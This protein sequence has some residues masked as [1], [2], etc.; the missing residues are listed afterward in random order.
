[1]QDYDRGPKLSE[2]QLMRE[3]A[4]AETELNSTRGRL[5]GEIA[6]LLKQQVHAGTITP[7]E[8]MEQFIQALDV[9]YGGRN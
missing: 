6:E 5:A 1:M 8:S 2:E 4:Y 9:I 7:K 3:R